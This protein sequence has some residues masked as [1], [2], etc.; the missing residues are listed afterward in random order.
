[1]NKLMLI[2]SLFLLSTAHA[3]SQKIMSGSINTDALTWTVETDPKAPDQMIVTIDL[4]GFNWYVYSDVVLFVSYT[5]PNNKPV[6]DS[7]ALTVP[8]QTLVEGKINK[9]SVKK[10]FPPTVFFKGV[11]L[12]FSARQIGYKV[13]GFQQPPLKGS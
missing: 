13:E 4:S 7:L 6:L 1:M 3:Y 5:S 8:K 12:K 2:A 10:N 11:K 9:I